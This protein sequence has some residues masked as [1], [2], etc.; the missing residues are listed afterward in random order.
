MPLNCL[1]CLIL[2]KRR[3]RQYSPPLC[4]QCNKP[5]ELLCYTGPNLFG[6]CKCGCKCPL[7]DMKFNYKNCSNCPICSDKNYIYI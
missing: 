2:F 5:I 6:W 7:N 4:P 1:C 3:K